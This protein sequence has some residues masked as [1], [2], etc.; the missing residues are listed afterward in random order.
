MDELGT[1][2]D[3]TLIAFDKKADE[4]H[5]AICNFSFYGSMN[6]VLGMTEQIKLQIVRLICNQNS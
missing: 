2:F 6:A 5:P 1:R 4:G 3:N